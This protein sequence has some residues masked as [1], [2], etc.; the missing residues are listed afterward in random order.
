MSRIQTVLASTLLLAVTMLGTACK[1][2]DAAKTVDTNTN[3]SRPTVHE[4]KRGPQQMLVGVIW[5]IDDQTGWVARRANV[6]FPFLPS[7]A[8]VDTGQ[9]A[10]PGGSLCSYAEQLEGCMVAPYAGMW[11]SASG[12]QPCGN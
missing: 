11:Q 10:P 2:G 8:M 1:S 3:V 7:D 6:P 9:A 5:K 4:V 12:W